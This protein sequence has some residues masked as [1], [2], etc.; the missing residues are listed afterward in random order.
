[1]GK[2]ISFSLASRAQSMS[3]LADAL[4]QVRETRP[5]PLRVGIQT[6][7]VLPRDDARQLE[8]D[9]EAL[10]VDEGMAQPGAWEI[11]RDAIQQLRVQTARQLGVVRLA[12]E[13]N[14]PLSL[15]FVVGNVFDTQSRVPLTI[16][17]KEELW[18]CDGAP[19]DFEWQ[20]SPQDE[21]LV[22]TDVTLEI[23]VRYDVTKQVKGYLLTQERVVRRHLYVQARNAS[24]GNYFLNAG[25]ARS[26]AEE[27][28]RGLVAHRNALNY[29]RLHIFAAIPLG[30]A[31]FIGRQLNALGPAQLYDWH[32][33][34]HEFLPT[35][36]IG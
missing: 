27:V 2:I 15:G 14:A 1:M 13:M 6:K 29:A 12:L 9:F 8:L 7:Y 31:V 25:D 17:Q 10:F 18:D 16:A 19:S 4:R 34:R 30:A 21:L 11:M 28:H 33:T 24:L 23:S 3:E 26:L 32:N 22:G 35:L 5:D 20:V 36:Q